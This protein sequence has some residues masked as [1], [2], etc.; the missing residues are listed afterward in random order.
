MPAAGQTI[1]K[2]V[3]FPEDLNQCWNWIGS[4]NK[5]TGYGK[6]TVNKKTVLAHRWMYEQMFGQIP[7]NRVIDH[8]CSNTRCVNPNHLDIVTQAENCR[9]G[10][11]AKLTL[12]DVLQ[13]KKALKNI[14]W[15]GRKALA[16]RFGVSEGLISDIK[17][18]R[19]WAGAED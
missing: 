11:G 12:S 14:K 18:G 5:K 3:D 2:M 9:R 7:N 6:K 1:K 16:E 8:K 19:A 10:K 13:I 17:Y 15:G 4:V